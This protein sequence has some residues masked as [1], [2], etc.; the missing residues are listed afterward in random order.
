MS[1][2]H[3]Y[4][5]KVKDLSFDEAREKYEAWAVA[6]KK[7]HSVRSYKEALRRLAETFGGK[8]LSQISSFLVE[9]HRQ[10]RIKVGARVRANRKLAVLKNLFSRCR[11]WNLF[12]G[13][14][15]VVSV[16]LTK[17][18]KQRLRVLEAEEEGRLLNAA[19]EPLRTVILVG[20]YRRAAEE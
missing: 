3:G 13:E 18:P 10:R 7:P 8:R 14:N 4:G 11:E 19:D 2:N 17:E 16:K 12:E 9:G 6:N 1:G 5:K 20:I 15:P